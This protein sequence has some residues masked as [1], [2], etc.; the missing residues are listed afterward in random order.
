MTKTFSKGIYLIW[1]LVYTR[2]KMSSSN[3]FFHCHF[4][5][6]NIL[7]TYFELSLISK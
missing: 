4:I 1:Q 2:M 7:G 3:V 6:I 5:A